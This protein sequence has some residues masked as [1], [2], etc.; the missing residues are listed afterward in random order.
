M[1]KSALKKDNK[2]KNVKQCTS[3]IKCS[4]KLLLTL[5]NL[6]GWLME[7]KD[8]PAFNQYLYLPLEK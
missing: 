1:K 8:C 7:S 6:R 4:I 5:P 2:F 3:K